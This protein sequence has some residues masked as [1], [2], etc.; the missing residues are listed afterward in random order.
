MSTLVTYPSPESAHY[1]QVITQTLRDNRGINAVDLEISQAP[2]YLDDV[3]S[4]IVVAPAKGETWDKS[5]TAFIDASSAELETKALI[6]VVLG[7]EDEAP[8]DLR[9][10][11][12]TFGARRVE[13]FNPA[14][15]A[16]DDHLSF[17]ARGAESFGAQ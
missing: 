8:A 3:K 6:L 5:A 17:W 9:V 1:A 16:D 10:V 7:D 4:V 13:Y 15:A 14:Q 12:D 11:L 2:Q